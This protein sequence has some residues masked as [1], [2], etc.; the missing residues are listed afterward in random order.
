MNRKE[1]IYI[2]KE[3][4]IDNVLLEESANEIVTLEENQSGTTSNYDYLFNK[5][6]I[7]DVELQGNKTSSDLKLQ[8]QMD[9][10]TNMDIEELFRVQE[11]SFF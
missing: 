4:D 8:E 3:Y 9:E 1:F 2:E 6:K 10:I 5:P 7:N 11:R